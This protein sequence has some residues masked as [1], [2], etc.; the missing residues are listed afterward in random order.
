MRAL[1]VLVGHHLRGAVL[2]RVKAA[3]VMGVLVRRVLLVVVK[4]GLVRVLLH[5]RCIVLRG[6]DTVR[7]LLLLG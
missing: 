5:L 4:G 1:M 7:L 3:R 6:G 2:R